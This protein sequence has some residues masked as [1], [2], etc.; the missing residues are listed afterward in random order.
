M[1]VLPRFLV[2][3][4]VI[5]L[6]A[7]LIPFGGT[8]ETQAQPESPIAEGEVMVKF[9]PGT[10][11][12]AIAE[13]HLA[14][15]AQVKSRIDQIDVEV[16][17]VPPGREVAAAASYE[18]NPN[19]KFAEPNRLYQ[20]ITHGSTYPQDPRFDDQWQYRNTG[21]TGGTVDADIDA[22]E[23]WGTT[24]GTGVKVAILDTGVGP[25]PDLAVASS[26]NYTG[27]LSPDDKYGHGTHVAGSV[28]AKTNNGVGVSGTCPECT[29][30]SYKVLNDAGSGQWD[31]IANG[32]IAAADDNNKA[33]NMSLGGYTPS[34]TLESAVNY[35]WGKGVV[36]AAAAGNDGQNWGLYPAAYTNAIAVGATTNTDARASFSNYGG[37]WVDVAAPGASILS[38]APTGSTSIWPTGTSGYA[39]LNGTSMA[40]PHVTGL[41]A[42]VWASG[43]CGTTDNACVRARIENTADHTA[44]TG[45]STSSFTIHGRIN[46]AAAVGASASPPTSTATPTATLT[47]TSTSTT[48]SNPTATP[49]AT[50]TPVPSPGLKIDAISPISMT[51]GTTVS[52][53]ITG[54]GFQTGATVTFENGSGNAPSASGVQV[55]GGGA[56]ITAN[57]SVGGGGPRRSRAWD[58]RVTN[59]G[60]SSAVKPGAFTVT[61]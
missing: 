52:I 2:F 16:V 9:Q 40:T 15:Q 5:A 30:S 48:G 49:T 22:Y 43:L 28:A 13:A 7:S 31:W 25:H 54:G 59:P 56:Q 11:G 18:H 14:Q 44:G 39:T 3:G 46:A 55:T 10:A 47:P 1:H 50:T 60:G 23:A 61:R 33:I 42:L 36:I 53:T 17:K 29:L 8:Q 58:V 19:V 6:C 45:T 20:A 51:A 37:N 21:Q 26:K 27:S 4:I 38:T 35:A 57:I 41:A 32:I 12:Q 34:Q 24:K